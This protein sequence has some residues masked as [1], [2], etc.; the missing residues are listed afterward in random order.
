MQ[1]PKIMYGT[2]WKKSDTSQ[3]VKLALNNG[4]K[5]I[6]TA[7]QP[8]HYYEPGV[9]D[10]LE[11][12]NR[13][14]IFLQTKFTS[15]NGQ[16]PKNC[17]YDRNLP[18]EEQIVTSFETSLKNLRTHYIDSLILHGPLKNHKENMVLWRQFEKFAERKQVRMLGVS[19][20]YD[21]DEFIHLYEDAVIK[22]QV[23]QNRFYSGTNYDKEIRQFCKENRI[24][25]QSF[26]TLTANPHIL[27]NVNVRKAAEKRGVPAT[28]LFFAYLSE[29]GI[30]PLTG[31]KN[32]QH[33]KDDLSA[34]EL[35]LT[36][37]EMSIFRRLVG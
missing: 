33:M 23:I 18:L 22:P 26:W 14:E 20:F 12:F 5:G 16:D 2:A 25:Y 7:C 19:N 13:E 31:T 37:E 24:I 34:M 3:F 15:I 28:S 4:F 35:I 1:M 27:E 30:V 8:K 21:V 32:V 11:N 29:T 9:G 6:D 17:P 10:A 36:D